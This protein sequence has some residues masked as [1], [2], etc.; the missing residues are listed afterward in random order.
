MVDNSS[1]EPINRL[2][3]QLKSLKTLKEQRHQK[4]KIHVQYNL[5]EAREVIV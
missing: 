2:G 1:Q 5:R 4:N 3:L